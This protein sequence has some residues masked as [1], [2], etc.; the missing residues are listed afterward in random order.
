MFEHCIPSGIHSNQEAT[1]AGYLGRRR[2]LRG[3]RQVGILTTPGLGP[4]KNLI[5][6][7]QVLVQIATR[8]C[9]SILTNNLSIL[10]INLF[11]VQ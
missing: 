7:L 8:R 3:Y 2:G 4:T 5:A 1:I 11:S 9:G 6:W 10:K